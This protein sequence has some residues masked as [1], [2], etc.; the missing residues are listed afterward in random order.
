[1]LKMLD[2]FSG[3]GGFSLAASWT[4]QIETVAFCEIE[5]YCQKVLNKHWTDV[6]IYPDIKELRGEDIGPID[7]VCG[8]F[9]CQP[10]ST[11]GK[12]YT[13]GRED[14]RYLWPEMLRIIRETKPPWVV[15]ENV[16]NFGRMELDNAFNDLEKEDYETVAFNIQA[17][18]V[19][20]KHP[21]ERI[22]IVCHAR[23]ES[24]LKAGKQAVPISTKREARGDYRAVNRQTSS[25]PNWEE[26]A[27]RVLRVADGIPSDVDR[28]RALGNAI[29]PQVAYQIFKA[30]VEIEG[31]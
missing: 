2:L 26:G 19:G 20:A 10:F 9:P 31:R 4:G 25:I 15:G 5:P 21:R 13:K 27:S 28:R 6:P 1:M 17:F 8:G 29:V 14:D 11:A 30:I 12:S 18:C 22:W 3:V 23:S 7:I 24:G 16:A